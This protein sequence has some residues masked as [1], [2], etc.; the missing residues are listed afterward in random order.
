MGQGLV[1]MGFAGAGWPGKDQIFCPG[2]PVQLGQI[3]QR[4]SRNRRQ[5]RIK[6]FQGFA[7]GVRPAPAAVAAD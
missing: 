7:L 2:H 3:I 4:L 1:E 6:R 5:S